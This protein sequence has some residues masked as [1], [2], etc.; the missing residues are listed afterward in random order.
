M[1]VDTNSFFNVSDEDNDSSGS[2]YDDMAEE[3]EEN[4]VEENLIQMDS[5][6]EPANTTGTNSPHFPSV[7]SAPPTQARGSAGTIIRH[8]FDTPSSTTT[9]PPAQARGSTGPVNRH[10]LIPPSSTTTI[11]PTQAR[12]LTGSN[13]PHALVPSPI[14]PMSSTQTRSS[15]GTNISRPLG[16]PTF[17]TIATP[18]QAKGSTPSSPQ[19]SPA[20]RG[21][22]LWQ[23]GLL[24]S[25]PP[26]PV[27][28]P[29]PHP[30]CV[31]RNSRITSFVFISS[32]SV[33][34]DLQRETSLQ[35]WP[36]G[37]PYLRKHLR[38]GVGSC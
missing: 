30:L 5:D 4:Q 9:I 35:R 25:D 1:D 3:F 10:P 27:Y 38:A 31:V 17:A 26:P 7:L 37:F 21:G 14:F 22:H 24:S 20:A 15:N 12:G 33:N 13:F 19:L 2:E 28:T 23:T 18:P 34:V 6:G 16:P 11:P 8:S 32:L 36:S 29:S